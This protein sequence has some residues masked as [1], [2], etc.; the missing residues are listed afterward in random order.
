IKSIIVTVLAAL[1][2]VSCKNGSTLQQY[3][4]DHQES[5][6][7]ITQDVPIS[8]LKIDETNLTSQQ[9]EALESVKRLNYLG[10]KIDGTKTAVY[11][12][13]LKK[14][15]AILTKET[16]NEL[17]DFSYQGTKVS[18]KYIGDDDEADEV[19]LFGNS[20]DLGFGVVRI[21]GDDMTP[22]KIITLVG[23]ME[24]SNVDTS[25]LND[26]MNFFK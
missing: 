2:L 23:L 22:S 14:V 6:N 11:E 9:K 5:K 10:Y 16:Y 12:T 1:F 25:Q 19:V 8:M 13:E 15:A 7:F 26:I 20:K 4:V 21:L 18:M 24:K 3:F 17:A